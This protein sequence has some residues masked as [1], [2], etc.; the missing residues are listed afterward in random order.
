[1]QS[2]HSF[3]QR[4]LIVLLLTPVVLM[5]AIWGKEIYAL[6]AKRA[7]LKKDFS[8]LNNIQYGLLSVDK[9]RENITDIVAMQIDQFRLKGKQEKLLREAL[10]DILN[11]LITQAEEMIDEPQ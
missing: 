11:S 10:D 6:S 8:E 2:G 7:E 1:M 4:A 5:C 3:K 9:W